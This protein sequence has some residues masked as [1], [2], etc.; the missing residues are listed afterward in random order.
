MLASVAC[1]AA[2]CCTAELSSLRALSCL[3]IVVLLVESVVL[4]EHCLWIGEV[5][6][7]DNFPPNF[8]V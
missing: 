7:K 1:W 3:S 6:V 2:S 4:L 8:C 5:Y